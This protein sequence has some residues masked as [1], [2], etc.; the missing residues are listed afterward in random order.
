LIDWR[1]AVGCGQLDA[2][3]GGWVRHG[4]GGGD[5]TL[6]GC[7]TS[8]SGHW[9]LRC[10]GN[11]WTTGTGTTAGAINCTRRGGWLGG[12]VGVWHAH[13]GATVRGIAATAEFSG[14]A[15]GG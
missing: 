14:V 6:V 15:V 10:H 8:S 13:G 9:R 3:A 1:T 11:E 7:D 5:V 2:P 12:C 4:G